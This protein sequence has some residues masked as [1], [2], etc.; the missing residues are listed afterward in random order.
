MV[1]DRAIVTTKDQ[2]KVV[3]DLSIGTI[4]NDFEQ[5]LNPNKD[6]KVTP[7]FDAEY[8]SNGRR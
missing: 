7:T 4:F 8:L 1:Q 6:F 5:T 3:Y 2:Y